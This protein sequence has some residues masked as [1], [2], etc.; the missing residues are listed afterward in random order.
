MLHT[1]EME[2]D[3]W[4]CRRCKVAKPAT[5]EYFYR[6]IRMKGLRRTCSECERTRNQQYKDEHREEYRKNSKA[7]RKK[8]R[9]EVNATQR[10][11][12]AKIR[13]LVLD[14][15]GGA[16]VC[17]GETERCFLSLDHINNDGYKYRLKTGRRIGNFYYFAQRHGFPSDLQILCHNCNMAKA[18]YKRCPHQKS[19]IYSSRSRFAET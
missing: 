18:A 10:I 2:G 3:I 5:P 1:E 14:H 15:Y 6:H 17:C 7:W 4:V 16:C 12:R 9:I 19:A 13:N 11:Y 8:H